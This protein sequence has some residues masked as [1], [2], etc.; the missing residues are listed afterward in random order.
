MTACAAS[1]SPAAR[2]RARSSRRSSLDALAIGPEIDP[3]VPALAAADG[4]RWR[5]RSNP[6]ISA[7]PTSSPRRCGPSREAERDMPDFTAN[8]AFL[9]PD[10]LSSIASR[11]RRQ[12]GFD[13]VECHFPYEF[14]IRPR[15]SG[16]TARACGSPASTRSPATASKGEWG[17]AGVPG[18]EDQFRRDFAQA[19]R[20]RRRARRLGDPRHGRHR[21][22]GRARRRRSDLRDEP[23]LRRARGRRHRADAPARA[24]EP[25]R[26][27]G[28]S[29]RRAPTTSPAS[30]PRSASRT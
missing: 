6:A 18:R 14:P 23:A 19:L 7:R 20:L 22:A 5:W 16:S 27:A 12:A 10:F 3:G 28:L 26:R 29:R 2:P 21:A 30:S 13:K 4:R 1:S 9:F 24:P 17:L 15:A 8:I 25:P 11:R